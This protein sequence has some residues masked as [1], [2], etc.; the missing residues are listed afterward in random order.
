MATIRKGMR[1]RVVR[2]QDGIA[3]SFVNYRGVI[4]EVGLDEPR[5]YRVRFEAGFDQDVPDARFAAAELQ[6]LQ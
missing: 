4:S 2:S 5:P 6:P 3:D 1:V